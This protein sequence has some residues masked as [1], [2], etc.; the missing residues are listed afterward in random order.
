MVIAQTKPKIHLQKVYNS[1]IKNYLSIK[2]ETPR[3]G[4][5]SMWNAQYEE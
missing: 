2:Y 1:I 3:M 4:A 5:I